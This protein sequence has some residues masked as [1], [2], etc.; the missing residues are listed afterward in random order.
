MI[1]TLIRRMNYEVASPAT[2]ASIR[3]VFTRG[4]A[5]I[6]PDARPEIAADLRATL[7]MMD[8]V[9]GPGLGDER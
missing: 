9:D 8:E 1:N 2:R 3:G 4:L 5:Q 7:A 6:D